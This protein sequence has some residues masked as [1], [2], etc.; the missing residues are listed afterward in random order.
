LAGQFGIDDLYLSLPCILGDAGVERVLL[1]EL[2]AGEQAALARSAAVLRDAREKLASGSDG[3][4]LPPSG[5][6]S[7]KA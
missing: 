6:V 4:A 7:A 3:Y 2:D 1:P 5:T